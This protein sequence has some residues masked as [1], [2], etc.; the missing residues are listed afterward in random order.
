MRSVSHSTRARALNF[1]TYENVSRTRRPNQTWSWS[2]VGNNTGGRASGFRSRAELSTQLAVR[3]VKGRRKGAEEVD[4]MS[5]L[6]FLVLLGTLLA[7]NSGEWILYFCL[8]AFLSEAPAWQTSSLICW[9]CTRATLVL[10]IGYLFSLM[11]R[12]FGHHRRTWNTFGSLTCQ[13]GLSTMRACL[14]HWDYAQPLYTFQ[15]PNSLEIKIV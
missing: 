1:G 15:I 5:P 6:R 9:N 10:F 14:S 4:K 8:F 7:A 12:V 2:S 11:L 13:S 3:W